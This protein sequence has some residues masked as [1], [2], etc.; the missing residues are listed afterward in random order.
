M[1]LS[2]IATW[3]AWSINCRSKIESLWMKEYLYQSW[4]MQKCKRRRES[5]PGHLWVEP[6]V[7]CHWVTTPGQ[8]P[9]LTIPLY[10]LHRWYWMP[11]LHTWQ[12][13]S[14]C[15]QYVPAATQHMAHKSK[16]LYCQRETRCSEQYWIELVGISILYSGK[17]SQI[18]GK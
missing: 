8:P 13:L 4:I 2:W 11:Q 17:L 15:R 16:F 14:M 7:L 5:N 9:T 12:P 10:V 3:T 1:D 6:S 18:G